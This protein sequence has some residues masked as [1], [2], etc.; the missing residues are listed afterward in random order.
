MTFFLIISIYHNIGD[1]MKG[2]NLKK[3][4]DYKKIKLI[5]VI[6]LFIVTT[7]FTFN[8]LNK[9]IYK[10]N[11]KEYINF[12][13]NLSFSTK[14]NINLI[15]DKVFNIYDKLTETGDFKYE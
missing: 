4:K 5:I 15:L 3:K 11:T 14:S 10:Y 6:V 2:M 12:Y 7:C 13:T 9:N 8:H 1:N